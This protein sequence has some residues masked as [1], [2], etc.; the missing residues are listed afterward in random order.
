MKRRG[1]NTRHD[2]MGIA[3]RRAAALAM[4]ALALGFAASCDSPSSDERALASA[5]RAMAA[6]HS[7]PDAPAADVQKAVQTEVVTT[8]RGVG[9]RLPG[10]TGASAW[11]LLAQAQAGLAQLDAAQAASAD[12]RLLNIATQARSVADLYSA[13]HALA[14]ALE[15]HDPRATITDLDQQARALEGEL[16]KAQAAR[17]REVERLEKLQAQAAEE[18][19]LAKEQRV[20][21]LSRRATA[22]H[23]APAERAAGYEDAHKLA[24]NAATHEKKA[25]EIEAEAAL[26]KP[27]IGVHDLDIARIT[28]Q[29][30]LIGA[31]KAQIEQA[32]KESGLQ[33]VESREDARA[34]GE[35]LAG[36][37]EELDALLTGESTAKHEAAASGFASAVAAARNAVKNVGTGEAKLGASVALAGY[38]QS[39][40]DL[41]GSHAQ[42]LGAV[43]AL[44]ATVKGVTPPVGDA[45]ALEASLARLAELRAKADEAAAQA[46]DGARAALNGSGAKGETAEKIKALQALLP[47]APKTEA[48]PAGTDGI[49]APEGAPAPPEEGAPTE[50]PPPAAQEPTPENAEPPPSA[51][52]APG[53]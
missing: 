48:P 44:V 30:E 6:L 31:S 46:Y 36:R 26:V 19:R 38:L 21:E 52:P 23:A 5:R 15:R 37:L 43:T 47:G 53:V 18:T 16:T 3:A 29:R 33:A 20:A 39:L 2:G 32:A 50:Q 9:E 17:Q 28:T 24:R 45:A 7:G 34:A 22:S 35:S 51:Q 40:G 27:L 14:T 1:D 49:P 4:S 8:L 25:A 12:A 13:Q 41:R 11:A 10:A 42:A